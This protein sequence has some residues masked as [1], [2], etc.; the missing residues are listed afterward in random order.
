MVDVN[1]KDALG[2]QGEQLAAEYL[3]REGMRI[4][5]RNWRCSEGEIDI[6]AADRRV[7]VACEVKT[8]SGTRYGTP[9]EAVTRKKRNR[10]R[11]L[12]VH[13]GGG[14]GGLFDEGRIDVVEVLKD[15]REGFTIEHIRG[16]G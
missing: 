5:A 4:L 7:L 16:V 13:W 1:A 2:Q 6:V 14:H 3:Q 8:R 10:L 15:P 12:A 11:R 9:L